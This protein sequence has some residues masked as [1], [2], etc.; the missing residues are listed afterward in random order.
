MEQHSH[1]LT[2]PFT[3][4]EAAVFLGIKYGRL[5]RWL[6]KDLLLG[7]EFA[8]GQGGRRELSWRDVVFLRCVVRLVVHRGISYRSVKET[9][10]LARRELQVGASPAPALV[11]VGRRVCVVTEESQIIDLLKGDQ[12]VLGAVFT[13]D[14][15][16]ELRLY[17]G[18]EQPVLWGAK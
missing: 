1:I 13:D 18:E 2:A 6:R 8:T 17:R 10:R 7:E 5:D 14:V 9:I 16:R 3:V 11:A 4:P 12:L 15:V